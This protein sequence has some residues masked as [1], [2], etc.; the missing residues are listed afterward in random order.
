[1]HVIDQAN[2]V[3]YLKCGM[4]KGWVAV[5]PHGNLYA[6]PVSFMPMGIFY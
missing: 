3:P 2:L 6:Y 4:A 1:M 5:L